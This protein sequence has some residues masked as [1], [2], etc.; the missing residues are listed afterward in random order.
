MKLHVLLIVAVLV[1]V[2]RFHS[3]DAAPTKMMKKIMKMFTWKRSKSLVTDSTVNETRV[4]T[5]MN[6]TPAL[7]EE[8][9]NQEDSVRPELID[10]TVPEEHH[11]GNSNWSVDLDHTSAW[12]TVKDE[13]DG[14]MI[15]TSRGTNRSSDTNKLSAPERSSSIFITSTTTASNRQKFSASNVASAIFD[16]KQVT[17]SS[18]SSSIE[19]KIVKEDDE[20]ANEKNKIP[21]FYG[22][23][24]S[25]H[26][27][28]SNAAHKSNNDLTFDQDHLQPA[29]SSNEA[30][31]DETAD[32]SDF[33]ENGEEP[34]PSVPSTSGNLCFNDTLAN[35]TKCY[36]Q[37]PLSKTFDEA[38][39]YCENQLTNGRLITIQSPE[40]AQFL[41]NHFLFYFWT[42]TKLKLSVRNDGE[43]GVRA[44]RPT[45]PATHSN[46]FE[47]MRLIDYNHR[48]RVEGINQF[49]LVQLTDEWH[50]FVHDE[51][52]E[53][54]LGDAFEQQRYLVRGRFYCSEVILA[55][56]GGQPI[57]V[58]QPKSCLF[59]ART[60][61]CETDPAQRATNAELDSKSMTHGHAELD[62]ALGHIFA[63]SSAAPAVSTSTWSVKSTAETTTAQPLITTHTPPLTTSKH[64]QSEEPDV[65]VLTST[66]DSF[67][68]NCN[69]SIR[70]HL[71]Y[72][73]S[74]LGGMQSYAHPLALTAVLLTVLLFCALLVLVVLLHT[75]RTL[76]SLQRKRQLLTIEQF[77]PN[78]ETDFESK[79]M[80][81]PLYATI[82]D[83]TLKKPTTLAHSSMHGN[84]YVSRPAGPRK[85]SYDPYY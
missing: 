13:D 32:A 42:A 12:Q 56:E 24:E 54:A 53:L 27:S 5:G 34:L 6:P 19:T 66:D 41:L 70:L 84:I 16:L 48:L 57:F 17:S 28:T 29:E 73:Q 63:S 25:G 52:D 31:V 75:C 51:Q 77:K 8:L 7:F 30:N 9:R 50:S 10:V 79:F 71:F 55:F 33:N 26:L 39:Q 65:V 62:D 2:V 46:D 74:L 64:N 47:R 11:D 58:W 14:S 67:A 69:R 45:Y 15:V 22:E 80:L 35:R 78:R 36:L 18:T 38:R 4:S 76:F 59:T 3:A 82:G 43:Y 1:S 61:I 81:Q 72:L 23:L 68:S 44:I 85:Y 49:D 40:E 21:N 20:E 60:F 37:V 83:D